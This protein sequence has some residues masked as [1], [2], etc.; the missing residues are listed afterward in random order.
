MTTKTG[1][2]V[3]HD[4]GHRLWLQL[5][6][7]TVVVMT[8]FCPGPDA[9]CRDRHNRC[10]VTEHIDRY[11]LECHVGQCPPE[12]YLVIAWTLQGDI[13]DPDESQVWVIGVSD[14]LFASWRSAQ[15]G[16]D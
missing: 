1:E 8:V 11:G 15:F 10:V 12:E 4:D 3:W 14:S 6:R 2:L 9:K 5:N 16:D 13:D 7:D